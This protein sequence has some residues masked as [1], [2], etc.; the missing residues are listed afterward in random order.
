[1][2]AH[3]FEIKEDFY[4]DGE[5][6]KIISGGIHYFRVVPEYWKDRLEK[7]KSLGC[8]TVETYVAWN[9]HEPTE[10]EFCFEGFSDLRH[11]I[12]L[13]QELGLWV[14]VRPAPFICAE[15]EFG[16]MP[17]WLLNKEGMRLRTN[18]LPFMDC[19]DRYYKK[20]FQILTPLQVNYGGPII[21]MQIENEYGY[22]GDDKEYL[23]TLK[24]L[25]EKYGAV[26]PFVTSDGPME[27]TLRDG[28]LPGVLPMGNFGSRTT[29]RFEVMKKVIGNRPFMCMEF[30]IGWFDAWECGKHNTSNLNENLKDLDDM[31]LLGHVNIY[32]FHGGT[33]FGFMNGSNF[34]DKLEA[35]VTSYD[36]DA[37]ITEDGQLTKK[38]FEFQKVISKYTKIP[39]VKFSTTIQR[40][41]YGDLFV[42]RKVSLFSVLE[43]ISKSITHPCT[44]SME[45]L[46]QNYGY[47]MYRT[48]LHRGKQIEKCRILEA[49]D[50][51]ILFS[52]QKKVGIRY[53][54]ELDKEFDFEVQ[55]DTVTLDILVENMGR[56]NYGVRLEEQHK[57][58]RKGVAFNG[59][60][61][62]NWTH[63][64]LPLTNLEQLNFD[65]EYIE[66]TPAFYEFEFTAD[67]A[68]D[69]F[70]ELEGWGKGC[71][72]VNEHNIGRFWEKGPQRRLYIP[73]PFI[74]IGMN[75]I[76]V[77]E[78]DGIVLDKISL[79]SIPDLG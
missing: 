7:L 14:I 66:N 51:A 38:Y 63:Y 73:A 69:T 24:G 67:E 15:W 35:D 19:V 65:K 75:K 11:F 26:V 8:N 79:K 9:V 52:N 17:A 44:L 18:T 72:F 5:K 4:L 20:L 47:T 13:A 28:G 29:E 76:I 12:E 32:M 59:M 21:M 16:G 1:M 34:Y 70:L 45:Q 23:L 43:D 2:V 56:V 53:N 30:W 42:K 58:I 54:L 33:N 60:L 22:Y 71:V 78:T 39:K 41:S 10:G 3:N 48:S 61:H 25:M 36:Y 46:G 27:Q 49:G 62:S 37:V 77:F 40:K 55:E 50:R 68:G 31:L 6:I 74:K 64:P 57:G